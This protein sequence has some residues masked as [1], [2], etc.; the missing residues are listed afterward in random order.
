KE[1]RRAARSHSNVPLDLY[2]SAGRM[3]IGEG[4]FLNVSLTGSLLESRQP[5]HLRQQIRLELQAPGRSPFH[6]A[7]KVVWRRKKAS[8][9]SYGIRFQRQAA[10]RV[11]RSA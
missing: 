5:L 11:R 9:F 6:L 2:D 8:A 1:R 3:I 10:Q 7:G 4:R